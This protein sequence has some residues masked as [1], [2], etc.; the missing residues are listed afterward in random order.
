[1]K[2]IKIL[3]AFITVTIS[4]LAQKQVF[5]V[6]N[7]TI[8]KGWDKTEMSQGIQL[9]ARNDGK[10]NYAT[11]IILS[12]IATVAPAGENFNNSWEKLVKGTVPVSEKPT[13]QAPAIEKGWNVISGQ[14]NYT[15]GSN[16]GIVTLMTATG[17]GKMANVLI[18][19]NTDKYQ[20]EIL[21]FI[22]SLGLNET[23]SAQ[24]ENTRSV[25]EGPSSSTNPTTGPGTK[26]VYSITVP[27]TWTL[28]SGGNTLT[29]EKN[30]NT[31]KRI[32]EFMNPVKSSGSLEKDMEHIFFEVFD[33]WNLYNSANNLLF[34]KGNHEKGFTGQGLP[35]YMLSNSISK[36]GSNDVI[37][38]TVLLI[39]AGT[40]VAVIN[41]ADIILGS[42]MD[43][44]LNFLL[45]NLKINGVAEKN[46]DYK[47][48]LIGTWASGSGSYG[49]SLIAATSYTAEGK[50][51]VLTQSSYTVGYDY[52][53]DLIK[54]KQFKGEG[55][56]AFKGNVLERRTGSGATSKYFIRFYS[57]K[58]GNNEWENVM[59]LYDCNYDKN[60]IETVL[61]FHKI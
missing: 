9:S 53:N 43:M 24:D 60:K 46:V 13:M 42:E 51:Y 32:I 59:G 48:Q 3:F 14:A 61:P 33:G 50:Y 37:K 12:S 5:D 23:A 54:N 19:T 35:Y 45:F 16:K 52:Y 31:G 39:Q 22:K 47:K 10:G 40:S 7:Y 20:K 34:E 15:D 25:N 30:T 27:P 44:A 41:S 26:N 38:G 36:K 11:A 28:N 21:G 2:K 49:N 4:C 55:A 18:M 17:N 58:Y 1:M 6:L 57:R 29:L 56:F 8:P